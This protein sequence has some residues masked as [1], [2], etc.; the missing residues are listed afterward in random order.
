MPKKLIAANWKM[1]KTPDEV[2]TFIREFAPLV[3]GHDRDGIAIMP[4]FVSLSALIEEVRGTQIEVGAQNIY[5]EKQGAFTGEI[6]AAMLVAIGCQHVIIGHSE[7]R[8]YF[9]ETDIDVNRKLHSALEEKLK[10]I[11]C[12]GEL[13]QERE[14]GS[15]RDVLRRQVCTALREIPA[16]DADNFCIAYEPVW[17]IGTGRIPTPEMASEAHAFIRCEA[18]KAI[19]EGP[20]TRLRILYGGSVKP[21]NASTLLSQQEIDG[22]LVGGASLD[23]KSLAAIV[24]W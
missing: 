23:P 17:A 11:V 18:E 2:R 21:E 19:G 15:T 10:A 12:V 16:R 6:S 20:A 24:K 22:A 8:R 4:P 13:L 9:G 1:N 7:R 5:W 3:A 14:S